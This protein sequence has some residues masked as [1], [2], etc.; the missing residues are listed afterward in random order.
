M[1]DQY[2]DHPGSFIVD[3]D[4]GIRVPAD[5]WALYQF[6]KPAYVA[7]PEAAAQAFARAGKKI[8]S[9]TEVTTDAEL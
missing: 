2:A 6:D 3:P 9:K 1:R 5:D 4:A 8:K 7:D